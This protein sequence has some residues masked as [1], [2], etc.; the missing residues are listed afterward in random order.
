MVT[1]PPITDASLFH[2]IFLILFYQNFLYIYFSIGWEFP[3]VLQKAKK[4]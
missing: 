1:S 4:D 3:P 2:H